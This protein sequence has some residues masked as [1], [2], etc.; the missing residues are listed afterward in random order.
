M[1]LSMAFYEQIK[2]GRYWKQ[3]ENIVVG[4]SGGVDSMVLFDL[5]YHLP[6]KV[7]PALHVA[8][9]NHKLRPESDG[10]EQFVKEQMTE[11]SVP[12]HVHTWDES[13][14]PVSG[15]E[16]EARMIRY[17]FFEEV[18]E[19]VGSRFILTAH[20]RDDQVETVL[21]RLVRGNS[22][23][24][25]TGISLERKHHDQTLIRLLLPYN[26]ES[27]E[28][29]AKKR[30]LSWKEDE[31]NRLALYTRNRYRNDIIPR[32]EQENA[33][34]KRHIVEFSEDIK[35]LL[36]ALDP[37]IEGEISRSFQ[38]S[39]SCMTVD[40]KSFS[41]EEKGFQKIVLSKAFKKW[42]HRSSY[43]IGQT[44]V[45]LLLDWFYSGGP[46]T[47]MDLP[48]DLVARKE[49]D[50]CIIEKHSDAIKNKSDVFFKERL[51]L[52]QWKKISE[53]ER[54]GWFDHEN[55]HE[56]NDTSGHRLYLAIDDVKEP[57]LLRHRK[58][59][60]RMKVKGLNGSKKVKDIFIDQKVPIKKRDDAW[61]VTDENGEIIWLVGYKESPLSLNA[62]TDTITY[63]LIYQK[64]S[65]TDN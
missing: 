8:H 2:T 55:F 28:D 7:R 23:D 27:I 12:V 31:S 42:P 63:V 6:E 46:N 45:K 4:V 14:H 57:L 9:V 5:L 64:T 41:T 30:Q 48:D 60:D 20:H 59:G 38:I 13:D 50:S 15:I 44:H 49:Y 33:A 62:L 43:A 37:L 1:S 47:Q 39:D 34:V 54:I 11:R 25:L 40:L 32:L 3:E 18:A 10:D 17:R 65:E 24:E 19:K 35:D 61:V 51:E 21:M 22:L 58:K 16:Q 56:E 36:K 52:N 29:Y 26:K 53:T